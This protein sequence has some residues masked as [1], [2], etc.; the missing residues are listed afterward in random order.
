MGTQKQKQPKKPTKQRKSSPRSKAKSR[1]GEFVELYWEYGEPEA[2]YVYG[3]VDE[4]TF[5]QA[6]TVYYGDGFFHDV[7]PDDLE[8]KLRH[9]YAFH[10]REGEKMSGVD[11]VLR[12]CPRRRGAM[13]MTVWEPPPPAER[14]KAMIARLGA[15]VMHRHIRF[16]RPTEHNPNDGTTWPWPFWQPPQNGLLGRDHEPVS[17]AHKARYSP[18]TLTPRDAMELAGIADAYTSLITH[19]ARSVRET[20]HDLHRAY[21]LWSEGWLRDESPAPAVAPATAPSTSHV[22]TVVIVEGSYYARLDETSH[23]RMARCTCGWLGP[24]RATVELVTDDACQHELLARDGIIAANVAP[25]SEV[26][27]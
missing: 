8:L 13:A 1:E 15:K 2:Y 11:S 14:A 19:P 5:R 6:L 9:V 4:A 21:G 17:A 22:T 18:H 25:T 23:T 26:L 20:L 10:S 7:E 27:S 12:E 3:H 24:E 16:S